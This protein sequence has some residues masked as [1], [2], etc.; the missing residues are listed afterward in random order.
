MDIKNICEQ[1]KNLAI[2]VGKFIRQESGN[3]SQESVEVKGLHDFVTY[4]DKTAEKKIVTA[5]QKILPEAGY[6]VEEGSITKKAEKFNWIVDPLDGTTN[7]IQNISPYAVSIALMENEK[8][9]L[10]VVYEISLNECFYS[11]KG[12][13]AY[14]NGVEI[15]VSK[16]Q[17][18]KDSFLATGFPYYDYSKLPQYMKSMETFLKSTIG[19]R[20]LGSAATDLI[21]VACGR[22]DVFYEYSLSPWDVAAGAFIVEQAGGKVCDFAGGNNY[23]FGKEIVASNEFVFEEFMK[24]MK[25]YF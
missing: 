7:F 1:T 2:E 4:V 21:Y 15:R 9:I 25:N 22:F 12:G 13:G 6:I 14:L 20:R 5:L 18:L 19:I 24:V 23:I 16:K 10:G 8:I 17:K 11:W 3:I